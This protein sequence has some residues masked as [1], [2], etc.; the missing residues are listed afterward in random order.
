MPTH[1]ALQ[2]VDR[3]AED[4]ADSPT[5]ATDIASALVLAAEVSDDDETAATAPVARSPAA[6][7][8]PA[9]ASARP[10]AHRS[11]RSHRPAMVSMVPEVPDPSALSPRIPTPER[12]TPDLELL[13]LQQDNLRLQ[14]ELEA[15]ARRIDDLR[16]VVE[17]ARRA[18][19]DATE[20]A[21]MWKRVA[22]ETQDALTQVARARDHYRAFALGGL[23][24]RVRGCPPLDGSSPDHGDA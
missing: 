1:P 11:G 24:D 15:S 17:G 13:V 20:Q 23:W 6:P 2:L 5:E 21:A 3:H 8:S 12:P 7:T 22:Q 18:S 4:D 14:R 10:A 9:S 19:R 16:A